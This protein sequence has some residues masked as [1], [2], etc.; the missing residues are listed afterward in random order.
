MVAVKR[1]C[2]DDCVGRAAVPWAIS[3][4]RAAAPGC[5][6]WSCPWDSGAVFG[7][8][9]ATPRVA[10]ANRIRVRMAQL[11]MYTLI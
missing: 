5:A 4:G 9:A 2:W 10:P 1:Y 11:R 6:D 8:Q 3:A 7:E